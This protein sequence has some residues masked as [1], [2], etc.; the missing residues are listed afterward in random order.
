MLLI[1]QLLAAATLPQQQL[2]TDSTL[3]PQ[4]PLLQ[5]SGYV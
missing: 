3:P 2:L 5:A 1:Q 4:Q